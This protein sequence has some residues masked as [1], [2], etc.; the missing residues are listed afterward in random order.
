MQA[1]IVFQKL[2]KN[3]PSI[4]AMNNS[5]VRNVMV[6]VWMYI[7]PLCNATNYAANCK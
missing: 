4:T 1:N 7:M 3:T 2:N 5:F 6:T